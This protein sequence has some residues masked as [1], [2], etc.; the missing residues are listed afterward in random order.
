MMELESDLCSDT[1]SGDAS[2]LELVLEENNNDDNDDDSGNSLNSAQKAALERIE[3][4]I[5]PTEYSWMDDDGNCYDYEGHWIDWI[6]PNSY[7]GLPDT[8]DED[9]DGGDDDHDG[10]GGDGDDSNGDLDCSLYY[11]LNGVCV[12]KNKKR[13]NLNSCPFVNNECYLSFIK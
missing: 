13:V 6:I 7:Y 12:G 5:W 3:H 2:D 10:N 4:A 8:E 1:D 9:E 11:Y